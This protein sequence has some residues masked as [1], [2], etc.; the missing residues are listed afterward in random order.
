[1]ILRSVCLSCLLTSR[2]CLSFQWFVG[3]LVRVSASPLCANNVAVGKF[4]RL[5]LS[6]LRAHDVAVLHQPQ[7]PLLALFLSF[8]FFF[9]N[10]LFSDELSTS[11]F[12]SSNVAS[13]STTSFQSRPPSYDLQIRWL[14]ENF[15]RRLVS[16][17]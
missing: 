3:R 17:H 16:Q 13:T 9:V 8:F 10:R 11:V 12:P 1:M 15:F 2:P 14:F 7:R 6:P 4:L 5:S